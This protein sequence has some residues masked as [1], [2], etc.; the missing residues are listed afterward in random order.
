[1]LVSA[2][3]SSRNLSDV[4]VGDACVRTGSGSD[5]I[6]KAPWL[7]PLNC[8]LSPAKAGAGFKWG[9]DPRVTLV[10]TRRDSL[11]P[12]LNSVAATRLVDAV[13]QSGAMLGRLFVWGTRAAGA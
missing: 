8:F 9:S 7:Q 3:K 5:R 12:G 2:S 1:M 10:P 13:I 11:H 4:D 6:I